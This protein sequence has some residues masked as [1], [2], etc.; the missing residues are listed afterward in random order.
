MQLDLDS[1]QRI[2]IFFLFVFQA[3]KIVMGSYLTLF[4]PQLCGDHDC[5]IYEHAST[6]YE[7]LCIFW[8]TLTLFSFIYM[9]IVELRRENWMITYL[10]NDE[11]YM[12]AT[13]DP[14]EHEFETDEM[15]KWNKSYVNAVVI[16][17]A[18]GFSNMI[19]SGI[20]IYGHHKDITTTSSLISFLLLMFS[21]LYESYH[22]AKESNGQMK[23]LSAYMTT[24]LVFNVLDVTMCSKSFVPASFQ[25][26]PL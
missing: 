25:Y 16:T 13:L 14:I 21:K 22:V 9:Y 2:K 12:K 18:A 7:Q 1:R 3:C 19:L 15:T 5:E 26:H 23:A 8:N 17:V 4:V 10:D 6:G 24:P 11:D 20:S